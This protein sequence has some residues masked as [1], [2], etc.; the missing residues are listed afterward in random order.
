MRGESSVKFFK[1]FVELRARTYNYLI[2]DSSK[3]K[4]AKGTKKCVIR[5]TKFENYR[6]CFEATQLENKLNYS[7]KN[8][9][10]VFSFKEDTKNKTKKTMN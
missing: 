10:N 4:K 2:D 3:D 9:M 7:E 6:H 8:K 1:K 5:K